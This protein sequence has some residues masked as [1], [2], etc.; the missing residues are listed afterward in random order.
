MY[1]SDIEIVGFKSFAQKI[2]LKFNGGLSAI[3]GPNGCGKTNVVDAIRWVLGEKKAST[4]RSDIM[5]NVIFNGTRDRKPLSMAEVTI[6]FDN[7]KSILPT[8]YSEV[9][10]TRRLFR[11]GDSEYFI[12]KTACRL[13][14]IS[15]LF[16]DT[17]IGPDSYSV[18]ELKMID[19]ILSGNVDDRRSM[20]EEA[21]GIKKYKQ[22][23][24]ETYKKLEN[25]LTDTERLNDIIQEVRKN[26]NSLSRQASKT[27]RYNQYLTRLKELDMCLLKDD[28]SNFT[29]KKS[30]L[31]SEHS[32]LEE[33]RFKTEQEIADSELTLKELK[34]QINHI[35]NKYSKTN[36]TV[37]ELSQKIAEA[38]RTSAVNNEKLNSYSET[39]A[40]LNKE[41]E[42]SKQSIA[43][44]TSE[45]EQI[46]ANIQTIEEKIKQLQI[47]KN[48]AEQN[49]QNIRNDHRTISGEV[50][51]KQNEYNSQKTKSESLSILIQRNNDKSKSLQMKLESTEQELF[52]YETQLKELASELGS[53][54]QIKPDLEIE[55]T[56]AKAS[57]ESQKIKKSEIEN[58]INSVKQQINDRLNLIS[59]RKSS[60]EFLNSLVDG[61]EVTKF[62]SSDKDWKYDGEKALL[63][64][65]VGCDEELRTAVSAAL[66]EA[67]HFFIVDEKANADAAIAL[68]QKNN[69]GKTG[70][71]CRDLIPNAPT[72]HFN[73]KSDDVIGL[74][75]ELVRVDDKIRNLLRH[76][77]GNTVIVRTEQAAIEL[78]ANSQVDRAVTLDGTVF[79][80]AGVIRGGSFSQKEGLW[81]G[82]KERL[83][84][85]ETEITSLNKELESFKS[86]I[87]KLESESKA[88]DLH[89]A[90][91]KLESAN[92]KLK[93]NEN[94]TQRLTMQKESL[95]RNI[96]MTQENSTRYAEEI[97]EI[98]EESNKSQLDLEELNISLETLLKSLRLKRDEMG[99]ISA[100][101]D[102]SDKVL[103]EFEYKIIQ[104]EAELKSAH[105]DKNRINSN[106]IATESKISEKNKELTELSELRI[107]LADS[108]VEISQT[109]AISQS[110]MESANE[111]LHTLA[112][113]RRV[114]AEQY[115][116]YF[117]EF[118]LR[119]KDYDKLKDK[120]HKIDIELA[121]IGSHIQNLFEKAMEQYQ[122]EIS[123]I[124]VEIPEDFEPATARAEALDLRAK[125]SELGNVNFMALDEFETQSERLD[126]YENQLNDLLESEKILRETIEEINS[127]AEHNFRETFDKVRAN[128]QML[129][130][131]LF[132]EEGD[133]DIGLESEDLLESDITITAKPPN[134]RPQS[135]KM[136]SGGEK[137]LTAIALLFAI[138]LVKPSPFCI[139]DEVDAPLDDLNVDKFVN[140][141]KD[142]S[143]ETQFLI[144]THNK[145]TMEA[146]ETLYG[147][148]MQE[149]GI[150]KVVS[151]KLNTSAA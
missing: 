138:Y 142:F 9:S 56:D 74:L 20:F 42:E 48:S 150:S 144:V 55:I 16:M 117:S 114:I 149:D 116:Q 113:D 10:I 84:S 107:K 123:E 132:G 47:E 33:Q 141:I 111:K 2:K 119:R 4:L 43:N 39:E 139:L 145:K 27:K 44:L 11:S 50:N 131:K 105:A 53:V 26:V 151:V 24:K 137:T 35:D 133:A 140:L 70:F 7:N 25:V 1:L 93:E 8:D 57:L 130:K 59:S 61:R 51:A 79:E 72:T 45:S 122:T 36:N 126:F 109:L 87:A 143:T 85:L 6:T 12:N 38:N 102:E 99:K 112:H 147:I 83:K 69:K 19:A 21:A 91:Q 58:E 94:Q 104:S 92:R 46:K 120:I 76:L 14:D 135:I 103:K 98:K 73:S 3:V 134:K 81:V 18:I 13:K 54:Q 124:N 128:F 41:I 97:N 62:L 101:L 23:R 63:G 34:E 110:E 49:K 17:G 40:R 64:E 30:S 100:K 136:L 37:N 108:S 89:S 71:V 68:L 125:L 148:T 118:E 65:L 15:D 67:A 77:L 52:K 90:E 28:M 86:Q 78:T 146:A 75:S 82:K 66:G 29:A 115:D 5:E 106:R 31:L 60:V 127:T 96:K 95:N 22:R 88:I 121:E 32:N 80:S 129:F